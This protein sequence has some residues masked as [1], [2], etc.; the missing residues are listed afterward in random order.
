MARR[1]SAKG[2]KVEISNRELRVEGRRWTW[3]EERRS[4]EEVEEEGGEIGD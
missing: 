3:N 1:E 2:K 4:W